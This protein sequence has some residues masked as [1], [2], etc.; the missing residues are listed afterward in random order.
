VGNIKHCTSCHTEEETAFYKQ[1]KNICRE[2]LNAQNKTRWAAQKEAQKK[3]REEW[4]ARWERE[5]GETWEVSQAKRIA[6]EAEKQAKSEIEAAFPHTPSKVFSTSWLYS[7][8]ETI[9]YPERTST[10]GKWLLFK[11]KGDALDRLWFQIVELL[12][13]GKLG[14]AAK[15]STMRA[16]ERK[17]EGV[18]C[19]YT[20]SLEDLADVRRIR[21]V[22]RNEAGITYPIPYKLDSKAGVEYKAWGHTGISSLYE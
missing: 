6:K 21:A 11:K 19:V 20:Y 13:A 3:E 7:S 9:T 14:R 15:V 4:L 17:E 5:H 2:C 22:L 12:K 10:S 8:N 1:H 16:D 18:I